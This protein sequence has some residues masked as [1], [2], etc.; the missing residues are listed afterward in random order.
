MAKLTNEEKEKA[1]LQLHNMLEK[2]ADLYYNTGHSSMSDEEFDKYKDLYERK[3]GKKFEVGAKPNHTN[4]K[5]V[6]VSH[7]YENLVGTYEKINT[8]DE[9]REWIDKF[10]DYNL[11]EYSIKMSYKY[12][13]NS[14]VTEC[15]DGKVQLALTRGRDGQGVDL[16]D[17]F[18]NVTIPFNEEMAVRYEVMLTWSEF[19]KLCEEKGKSYANPRSLVAGTISDSEAADYASHF[20]LVPLNV[21]VK[22]KDISP[23]NEIKIINVISKGKPIEYNCSIF[24]GSKEYV[25]KEIEKAYNELSTSRFNFDYMIDGLVIEFV[26]KEIRSLGYSDRGAN[27]RPNF[28][29]ALKFPYME[30]ETEVTGIEWEVSPNGTGRITP[31]VVFKPVKFNGAVQTRVSL[32][33]LKRYMELKPIGIGTKGV[34]QYRNDVLSYFNKLD[35]PENAKIKHIPFITKCPVCNGEIKA[36]K[37]MTFAYCS[38]PDCK[39]KSIGKITNYITQMDIKGIDSKTLTKLY[40]AGLLNT[41]SDLYSV[42]YR[43]MSKL[44]G[45]GEKSATN[46]IEAIASKKP[47]DYELLAGLGIKGIA[48]KNAKELLKEFKLNDLANLSIIKEDDFKTA[49][50]NIEGFS[51]IMA[52]NL[53]NGLIENNDELIKLIGLVDFKQSDQ[54]HSNEKVLK[55][56]I[57]GDTIYFKDRTQFIRFVEECGHK[58][59]GSVSKNTDYL[60]TND[61]TTG[62]VKNKK[63]KELGIPIITDQEVAQMFGMKRANEFINKK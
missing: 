17:I 62:T 49:V 37:N 22:G 4:K 50:I 28:A 58:V 15:K 31:M 54:R 14:V 3:S 32:A 40:E 38:N 60:V 53:I 19:D 11:A 12:D 45:F 56:V 7:N 44:E 63:A 2:A 10:D 61:T 52:S 34:I 20:T 25:I 16:T 21:R 42:S 57:T 30:K 43:K 55:F 29:V 59:I 1:L 24:T 35:V 23:K 47:Y 39:S 6:N 51:N 46:F 26:N 27:G 36:N 33:N 41:I 18:K 5:V 13:G 48:R 8:I 9:L